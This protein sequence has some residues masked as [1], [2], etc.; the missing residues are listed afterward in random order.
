MAT[1]TKADKVAALRERLKQLDLGGGGAGFYTPKVGKNV[2]R[3]LPETGDM[4]YFFQPVGRH[5]FPGNK[6]VYCPAFTT[7]KER[8][9]PVCE[10]VKQLHTAGDKASKKLAESLGVRRS[11]WMNVIDR[12]N[13]K[14]GPLVFTPGVMVF[15]SIITY[16]ND[17]DYGDV[18]DIEDGVDIVI[19]RTGTGKE[20]SYEIIARR[21]STPL[22]SDDDT[23]DEW[24]EKCRDLS[25]VELTDDPEEDKDVS[26]GHAVWVLPYDRI[27]ENFGLDA[28]DAANFEEEDEEPQPKKSKSGMRASGP[29]VKPAHKPVEVEDVDNGDDAEADDDEP[30]ARREVARRKAARQAR[31]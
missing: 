7:E 25:W 26:E 13:E 1:K 22:A 19:E 8:E 15:N 23:I 18:T 14:A 6:S 17:P 16:I 5:Y 31:R 21:K 27:V 11:W 24:V 29:S 28:F 4:E 9:C 10:I 30:P 12:S 3:I 2:I 20:T